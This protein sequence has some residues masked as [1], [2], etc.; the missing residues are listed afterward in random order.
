MPLPAQAETGS[1][2]GPPL[3]QD[4][5]PGEL[6]SGI[7]HD[8]KHL[9]DQYLVLLRFELARGARSLSRLLATSLMG[10]GLSCLGILFFGLAIGHA[11]AGTKPLAPAIAYATFA[12]LLLVIGSV[13]LL[14]LRRE[15]ST[16][17]EAERGP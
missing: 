14:R 15:P 5:N 4:K 1:P 3:E 16:D 13:L 11:S 17:A 6:L 10:S 12:L 9:G 8:A 7:V 2:G